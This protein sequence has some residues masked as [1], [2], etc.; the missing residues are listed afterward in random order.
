MWLKIVMLLE[1][2]VPYDEIM[3]MNESTIHM[4]LGASGAIGEMRAKKT[5]TP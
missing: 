1:I 5:A 3:H 4:I 2:G